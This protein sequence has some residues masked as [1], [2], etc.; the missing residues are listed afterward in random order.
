MNHQ[1]YFLS[2]RG[3]ILPVEQTHIKAVFHAP[4]TFGVTLEGLC[5]TYDRYHEPYGLEGRARND[6]L[7][8]LVNN[9][10]IRV[11]YQPRSSRFTFQVGKDLTRANRRALRRF[12]LLIH[13]GFIRPLGAGEHSTALLLTSRGEVLYQGELRTV[14]SSLPQ[15]PETAPDNTL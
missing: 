12:V 5:A 3:T 7:G 1:A 6:V 4:G 14:L 9:G 10:W 15:I 2:P 8:R 11:R 13:S